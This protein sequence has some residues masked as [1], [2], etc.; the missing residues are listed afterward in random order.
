MTENKEFPPEKIRAIVTEVATLLKE[1]GE[2][3][4]VA[5]TVRLIPCLLLPPVP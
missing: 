1:K 3:A 4:S 5:E 2:S